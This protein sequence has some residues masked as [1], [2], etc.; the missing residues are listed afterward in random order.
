VLDFGPSSSWTRL[1]SDD[2]SHPEWAVIQ[3]N[4]TRIEIYDGQTLYSGQSI[5]PMRFGFNPMVSAPGDT[6]WRIVRWDEMSF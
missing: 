6:T 3:V 5:N 2:P 1:A 4:T